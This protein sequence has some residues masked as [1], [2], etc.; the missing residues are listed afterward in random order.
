MSMHWGELP[1]DSP[2]DRAGALAGALAELSQRELLLS[3]AGVLTPIATRVT[4]LPGLIEREIIESG[5]AIIEAPHLGAKFTLSA[6]TGLWEA[7]TA[8][9]AALLRAK[10]HQ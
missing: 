2:R 10:F 7:P 8:Q 1:G 3:H 4:D 5:T 9:V 6:D